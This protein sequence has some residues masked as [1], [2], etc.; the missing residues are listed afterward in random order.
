M[1]YS[2]YQRK[3]IEY[4]FNK[5]KFGSKRK[6]QNDIER[7]NLNGKIKNY[8]IIC[9]NTI[10]QEYEF[11]KFGFIVL[12]FNT[13][14]YYMNE[15]NT[16]NLISERTVFDIDDKK[17]R[18]EYF[19]YNK[20]GLIDKKNVENHIQY[21]KGYDEYYE[22]DNRDNRTAIIKQH[23]NYNDDID[24]YKY[25]SKSQ[26]TDHYLFTKSSQNYIGRFKYKYKDFIVLEKYFSEDNEL[27]SS[28]KSTLD[29]NNNP[30]QVE[31]YVKFMNIRSTTNYLY[32]Y[33]RFKN[34]IT[35]DQSL[36]GK[37]TVQE[38]TQIEYFE[39]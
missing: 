38:K 21:D 9:N 8:K 19:F 4:L 2:L 16:L 24:T 29:I 20:L 27:L 26:I 6:E 34:W 18:S 5:Y 13:K 23:Q 33:D 1:Y 14:E 37:K 17:I 15:Y 7:L 31:K 11:N 36:N 30:I 3:T 32:S 25:N 22:Y 35:K 39:N 28:K 10:T 12:E